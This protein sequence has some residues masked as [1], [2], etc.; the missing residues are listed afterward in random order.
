MSRITIPHVGTFYRLIH[1][2]DWGNDEIVELQNT[3]SNTVF[4]ERPR[5]KCPSSIAVI[6]V[7]GLL[8]GLT[9]GWLL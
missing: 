9:T 5:A 1:H 8:F 3:K 4:S 2:T 7:V 6:H